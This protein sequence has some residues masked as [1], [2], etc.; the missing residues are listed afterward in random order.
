MRL[1]T[2]CLSL[3]FL[4][5]CR[6]FNSSRLNDVLFNDETGA[7]LFYPKGTQIELKPCASPI[8]IN[9]HN[10]ASPGEACTLKAGAKI[11]TISKNDLKKDLLR[12]LYI[13]ASNPDMEKLIKENHKVAL[14]KIAEKNRPRS[15]SEKID[16]VN[17]YLDAM[18]QLTLDDKITASAKS[19]GEKATQKELDPLNQAINDAVDTFISQPGLHLVTPSVG[20]K[21]LFNILSGFVNRHN[22][23]QE[24]KES[25]DRLKFV[26]IPPG[27]FFMGS[28]PTELGRDGDEDPLHEVQISRGFDLMITEVTQ[29]QWKTIMGDNPSA[30]NS[31]PHNPVEKVNWEDVQ[32]FISKLNEGTERCGDTSTE[33]GFQKA[34]TTSKCY[35]LPTEAEW[36]YAARAGTTTPFN[37]GTNISVQQANFDSSPPSDRRTENHEGKTHIVGSLPN[38]NK[39]GLFDMHGNV[40]EWTQDWY[41]RGY[42]SVSPIENPIGPSSIKSSI[43]HRSIRGGAWITDR[44]SLR[45]AARSWGFPLF[46]YSAIGF[47]LAR[48]L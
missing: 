18:D 10:L 22:L 38:K 21:L 17:A 40:C 15:L 9:R 41:D 45:S 36:E 30:F 47:R 12:A 2:I 14:A 31:H 1:F 11:L 34:M 29:A 48:T 8:S 4:S 5:N 13:E 16:E 32:I 42:Y 6:S 44:N 27:K 37:L 46:R 43:G 26:R 28:P 7:I 24:N 39:M 35:R 3:V 19:L 23:H 33:S 20:S 25:L